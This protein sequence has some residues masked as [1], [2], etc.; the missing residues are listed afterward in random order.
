MYGSEDG[1]VWAPLTLA[2]TNPAPAVGGQEMLSV[3]LPAGLGLSETR[4][5]V[6][7][8]RGVSAAD[9]FDPG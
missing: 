6:G 5:I 8:A 7:R 1:S 3:L 9:S 2:S 4:R